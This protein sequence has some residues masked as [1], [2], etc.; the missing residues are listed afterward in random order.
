M[1]NEINEKKKKTQAQDRLPLHSSNETLQKKCIR[2]QDLEGCSNSSNPKPLQSIQTAKYRSE[3]PNCGRKTKCA[4][5][6]PPTLASVSV[7][8][9]SQIS[10]T[11]FK[12]ASPPY[13][14][15]PLSVAEAQRKAVG[16]FFLIPF[17]FSLPVRSP[18]RKS[19]EMSRSGFVSN[20]TRLPPPPQL[21]SL[22]FYPSGPRTFMS[23]SVEGY[24]QLP[25]NLAEGTVNDSL[26]PLHP[27][28]PTP[29]L[30]FSAPHSHFNRSPREKKKRC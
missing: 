17:H 21:L 3:E 16:D 6:N 8:L 20:S 5:G 25:T 27:P 13:P 26:S 11:F 15:P 22:S 10:I 18:S 19:K 29:P 14:G 12:R 30:R 1:V 2:E 7:K 23:S 4:G 28:L 24:R 9:L